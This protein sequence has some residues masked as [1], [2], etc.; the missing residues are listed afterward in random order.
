MGPFRRPFRPP[1]HIVVLRRAGVHGLESAYLTM[2]VEIVGQLETT[3][4]AEWDRTLL[5]PRDPEKGIATLYRRFGIVTADLLPPEVASA[6]LHPLVEAIERND[7]QTLS[8]REAT[9]A[10]SASAPAHSWCLDYVGVPQGYSTRTGRGVKV[11]VLDTGLSPHPDLSNVVARRRF[12]AG[13]SGP[14]DV[15]DDSGHGTG[16]A[17]VIAGAAKSAGKCRYGVA[18]DVDLLIGK[19][20]RNRKWLPATV[21]EGLNWATAEGAVLVCLSLEK[22]RKPGGRFSPSVARVASDLAG[23]SPGAVIV[24]AAGNFSDRPARIEPVANPAACPGIVAVAALNK[25]YEVARW[26][27]GGVDTVGHVHYAAPGVGVHSAAMNKS[28]SYQ[29]GTSFAA[30]HVAGV[31]ALHME[32]LIESAGG[33]QPKATDVLSKLAG[34]IHPLYPLEDFGVGIPLAP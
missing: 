11:A 26:S 2:L 28:Y 4:D 20:V 29:E 9:V 1:S 12:V 25:K 17:G 15:A 23:A 8:P 34:H 6:R 27:C 18:P 21:V 24:A 30:P 31:A 3:V 14:T 16:V 19:V 7:E 32:A 10:P 33:G 22:Y 13:G 5:V